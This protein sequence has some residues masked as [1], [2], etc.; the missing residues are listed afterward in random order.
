MRY[1][2]FFCFSIVILGCENPSYKYYHSRL[3]P[4]KGGNKWEKTSHFKNIPVSICLE[5]R[6]D[7]E[8]YRTEYQGRFE[9]VMINTAILSL[10]NDIVFLKDTFQTGTNLLE[11]QYAKIELIETT[12]NGKY[13]GDCYLLWINKENIS[14]FFTSKGYYTVYFKAQTE[15]NYS[16][17]DS[18]VIWIE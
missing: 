18:T 1:I 14:N 12:V 17:N 8:D 13:V 15:H 5:S 7:V 6:I 10:D 9:P 3:Y 11:T 4:I 2:L 16:I